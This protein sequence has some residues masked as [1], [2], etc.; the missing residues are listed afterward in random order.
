M[1]TV[2]F[3]VGFFF[4][5]MPDVAKIGCHHAPAL[6]LQWPGIFLPLLVVCINLFQKALTFPSIGGDLGMLLQ[7]CRYTSLNI[8][9]IIVPTFN[10][11]CINCAP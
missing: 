2:V 1:K 8:R 4:F 5:S 6:S 9:C 10:R 3:V 7:I 11:P